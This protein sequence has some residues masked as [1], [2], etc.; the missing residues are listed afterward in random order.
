[1][2]ENFRFSSSWEKFEE[3]VV[4]LKELL[5]RNKAHWLVGYIKEFDIYIDEDEEEQLEEETLEIIN[6]EI[7]YL[8]YESLNKRAVNED[9]IKEVIQEVSSEAT[10]D[11]VQ[12]AIIS[13]RNK[14]EFVKDSFEIDELLKRYELKEDSVNAKLSDFR[15]NIYKANLPDGG[16]INCAFISISS[17]KRLEGIQKAISLFTNA[18]K[19]DEVCFMCDYEDINMMIHQLETVKKKMEEY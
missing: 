5:K 7:V 15:Y 19:K 18:E 10:E 16:N 9:K 6:S 4:I 1:M 12:Q 14:L 3:A 8:L 17:Q 2:I 13:F 11:N